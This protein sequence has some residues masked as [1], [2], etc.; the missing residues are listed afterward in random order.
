[1]QA[2][3][4]PSERFGGGASEICFTDACGALEHEW[5]FHAQREPQRER[6]RRVG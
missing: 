1:L 5:P 6:K 3:K 2:K 4:R